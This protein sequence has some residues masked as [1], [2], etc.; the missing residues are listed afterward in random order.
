[1]RD[2]PMLAAAMR[3]DAEDPPMPVGQLDVDTTGLLLFTDDGDLSMLINTPGAVPK[4]Y[5]AS[6]DARETL[7]APVKEL[8]DM[9]EVLSCELVDKRPLAPPP[10]QFFAS[11]KARFTFSLVV[12][13]GTFHIVKKI[14]S[15]LKLSVRQLH[16]EQ[17]GPLSLARIGNVATGES[18]ELDSS[19]VEELWSAVGE[20]RLFRHRL[21]HLQTRASC[22]RDKRLQLF[23]SQLPL[24]NSA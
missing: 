20:D 12:A 19:Q 24:H 11:R 7:E 16:R 1:M 22:T 23:L 6:I 21:R 13:V 18:K 15:R 3:M 9:S 2:G 5:L 17:V 4:R 14:F 10:S 8:N